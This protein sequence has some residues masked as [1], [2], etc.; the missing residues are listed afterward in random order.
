MASRPSTA[1][2]G[3]R[4]RPNRL[5]E[6]I[7]SAKLVDLSAQ[8]LFT[9]EQEEIERKIEEEKEKKE[10]LKAAGKPIPPS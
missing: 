6:R 2:I 9:D 3:M 5:K 10:K 7:L 1:A 8:Y 4:A